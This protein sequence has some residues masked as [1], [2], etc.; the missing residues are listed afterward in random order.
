MIKSKNCKSISKT[1]K[2]LLNWLGQYETQ[3]SSTHHLKRVPVGRVGR[4]WKQIIYAELTLI[5]I[6]KP[7]EEKP[8]DV[9]MESKETVIQNK[10]T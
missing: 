1:P 7:I 10:E 9:D 5:N 2:Y 3:E 4:K 8:A 6:S